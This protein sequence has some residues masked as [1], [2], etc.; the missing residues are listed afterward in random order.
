MWYFVRPFL[1]RWKLRLCQ[2]AQNKRI[3]NYDTT[4]EEQGTTEIPPFFQRF[5]NSIP[6]VIPADWNLNRPPPRWVLSGSWI[7][8][9]VFSGL[10]WVLEGLGRSWGG[11]WRYPNSNPRA[12]KFEPRT[13]QIDAGGSQKSVS[14]RTLIILIVFQ[15]AEKTVTVQHVRNDH[16]EIFWP[17]PPKLPKMEP[18]KWKVRCPK[19]NR[20]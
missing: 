16:S 8:W 11:S 9:G 1:A 13:S 2:S 17:Q 19:A 4:H 15:D 14:E 10:W 7:V 6:I 5:L 3:D 20:F 12:S 18:K